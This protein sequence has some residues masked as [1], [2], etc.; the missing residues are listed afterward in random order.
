M[1]H[2]LYLILVLLSA[3]APKPEPD[4]Q[5]VGDP[6]FYVKGR[7]NGKVV[8]FNA[9]QNQYFMHTGFIKDSGAVVR[10]SGELSQGTCNNC[11]E[12]IQLLIRNYTKSASYSIDTATQ[13][14]RYSFYDGLNPIKTH[15]EADFVAQAFNGN[16]GSHQ[17][18]TGN[19]DVFSGSYVTTRYNQTGTY[20][21]SLQTNYTGGCQA[22]NTLQ[23]KVPSG[24]R[25][26]FE[27][28]KFNLMDSNRILFN[29]IPVNT[30]ANVS[31]DFGD[32]NTGTGSIVQH[33]YNSPGVYRVCMVYD[34]ANDSVSIRH[35]KNVPT[36][37][38]A[39]CVT[40]MR[41]RVREIIDGNQFSGVTIKW[42]D[43]AGKWYSSDA[44][45]QP[46]SSYFEILSTEP[47]EFNSD[48]Y[49]T[50]KMKIR[51]NCRVSDGINELD[52]EQV[53]AVI[54][55]AYGQ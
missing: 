18:N 20:T 45:A 42:K 6:I 25:E 1:K 27:D 29:S 40:N 17:W 24:A 48:R 47:Y 33:A 51:V 22:S 32:G 2:W 7:V 53:E 50:Q 3:C 12:A 28:F 16:V 15:Y 31:W 52:L 30:N 14:G 34:N 5:V 21:V 46:A 8:T 43:A 44:V 19:G 23:V 55:V 39:G 49:P 11:G 38:S 41:Y 36:S 4:D 26:N 10:F 9:G 13:K 54:A 35:C 37:N